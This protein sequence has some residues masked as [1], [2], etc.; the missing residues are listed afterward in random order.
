MQ[1]YTKMPGKEAPFL[2][3]NPPVVGLKAFLIEKCNFMIGDRWSMF[4]GQ[5]PVYS[6]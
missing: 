3:I 6:V 1:R 5:W 2:G 4:D